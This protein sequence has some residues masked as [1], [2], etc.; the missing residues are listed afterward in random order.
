MYL[1]MINICK[2]IYVHTCQ[3]KKKEK[4]QMTSISVVG[5]WHSGY[6]TA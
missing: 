1:H 4:E 6:I 5:V 3:G 2:F